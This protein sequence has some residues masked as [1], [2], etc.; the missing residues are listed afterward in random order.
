MR[1]F[2][3]IGPRWK[4]TFWF[5]ISIIVV[6]KVVINIT[7]IWE[8][9]RGFLSLMTPFILGF[10]IAYFLNVPC[11]RLENL[12]SRLDQP[13]FKKRARALGI[14]AAYIILIVCI[15][16]IF[17]YLIPIITRSIL[18]LAA[19][20]P[21]YYN[22]VVYFIMSLER[23]GLFAWIDLE[24]IL[25]SISVQELMSRLT[26]GLGSVGEYAMVMTTGIFRFVIGFIVS[27]Y[28]LLQKDSLLALA[29]RVARMLIKEGSLS[30]LKMYMWESNEIFYKFIYAQFL[31]ACI[32]GLLAT[33]LLALIGVPYAIMF[34][35]LLLACN[36]IP[37][38]GS[39]VGTAITVIIT[40]FTSGLN[41]ALTALVAL[42]ILQQIDGNIIGP[43]LMGESLDLSPIWIIMS[44]TIGG[45]YFGVVGM[46]LSV[47]VAALL[48]L[49]FV[50]LME[51]QEAKAKS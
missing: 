21:I 30:T 50:N 29:D 44:L 34:G 43:R 27:I 40:L 13:F 14:A 20:I 28:M 45:A 19:H 38:F 5:V 46:F 15:S 4:E 23:D 39:L 35:F 22:M 9:F 7:P 25:T 51:A 17:S 26:A 2:G 31:D 49:I 48:K 42:F 1:G 10:V 47:P 6:Y 37:Y 32:L 8:S 11:K 3:F 24:A 33:I 12:F 18:D 41:I 16:V 36:M